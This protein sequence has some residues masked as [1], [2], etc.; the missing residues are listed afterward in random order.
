[1]NDLP[2]KNESQVTAASSQVN[3]SV[4]PG[5]LIVFN[6]YLPHQFRVDDAYEPFSF[7]HFNCRA[8]PID[9]VLSNYTE[10]KDGNKK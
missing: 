9:T 5:D 7:I 6:S 4:R 1:M 8:I 10:K 3:Y 2:Q